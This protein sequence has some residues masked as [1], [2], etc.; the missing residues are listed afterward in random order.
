MSVDGI[1]QFVLYGFEKD[2]GGL[3]VPVIVKG[4]S[5]EVGHLLVELALA[6]A[7]FANIFKQMLK[8]LA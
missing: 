7:D 5:V 4:R 2:L 1:V 3:R 8:V 6:K